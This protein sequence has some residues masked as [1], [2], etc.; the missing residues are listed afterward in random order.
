MNMDKYNLKEGEITFTARL[1]AYYQAHKNKTDAPLF[2][3]PYAE[4]L[5][6]DLTSYFKTDESFMINN[7]PLIRTYYIDNH[8]LI[9]WCEKQNDS[10][11]IIVGAGLDARA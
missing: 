6:G 10:Q 1:M 11:V 9:P 3:D 7:Y 4:R 5:A 2:S 8:L